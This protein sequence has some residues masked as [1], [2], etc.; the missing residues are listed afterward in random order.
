ME[1]I[2]FQP[3]ISTGRQPKAYEKLITSSATKII[4]LLAAAPWPTLR[5]LLANA[6]KYINSSSPHL[7]DW[8]SREIS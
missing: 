6:G 2:R 3:M 7:R 5:C 4:D 1:S 8:S